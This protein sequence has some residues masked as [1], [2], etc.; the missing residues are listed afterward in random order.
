V[1][2]M[3]ASR[4]VIRPPG[5]WPGMGFR[6]LARYHE[7]LYFLT[8]R[9]VLVRYKQ[10]LFGITWV[11]AQP[12]AYAFVF[13][14]FFGKLAKIP[15][16]GVPY[17]VFALAALVPW[18][19]AAQGVGAATASLVGEANLLGKIYFP[20]LALP[21]AKLLSFV[22]DLVIGLCVLLVFVLLYGVHPTIGL[23]AVPGFLAIELLTVLGV[24]LTL[25]TLNVKYRDVT[26][27][28]PLLTQL[29][30]FATPVLYPGA[31]I[32]GT[33]R[34]IYALNPMV[35]VIEGV[36]WAFVGTDPPPVGGIAVSVAVA[37]GLFVMGITYF[38]RAEHYLADII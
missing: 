1:S 6:E 3:E 33:W 25:G 34:Y 32:T 18:I 11:I 30:L 16:E 2:A 37:I 24:G 15:S 14:I 26:V 27:A 17:P 31:L 20:R 4:V 8:R 38:R 12:L 36:R 19:F 22:L 35:S 9:D 13:A 5:R 10:S 7:L 28:V 23:L 21:L 29:W